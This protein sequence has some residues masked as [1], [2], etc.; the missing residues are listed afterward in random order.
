MKTIQKM[1]I[2]IIFEVIP[3][4]NAESVFTAR[5]RFESLKK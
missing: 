5:Q 4:N 1:N 2:I 3:L